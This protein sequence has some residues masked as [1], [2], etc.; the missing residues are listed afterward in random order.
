MGAAGSVRHVV[1][2]E[3]T[4]LREKELNKE[5]SHL[6]ALTRAS[7]IRNRKNGMGNTIDILNG[8]FP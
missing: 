4:K 6:T 8:P 2:A 7:R 1:R 5:V 3:V